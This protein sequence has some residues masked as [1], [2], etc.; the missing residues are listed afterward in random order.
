MFAF[1]GFLYWSRLGDVIFKIFKNFNN[2]PY[3]LEKELGVEEEK[4]S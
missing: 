1:A 3:Y 2:F 4:L